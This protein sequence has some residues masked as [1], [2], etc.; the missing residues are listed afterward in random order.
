MR[1]PST[2]PVGAP[3]SAAFAVADRERQLDGTRPVEGLRMRPGERSEGA[4]APR[5]S[6]EERKERAAASARGGWSGPTPGP[7]ARRP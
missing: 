2:D 1:S 4:R 7:Y 6:G 5:P 3:L